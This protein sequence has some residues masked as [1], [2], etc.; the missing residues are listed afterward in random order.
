[1]AFPT[2]EDL[3]DYTRNERPTADDALYQ[4]AIDAAIQTLCDECQREFVVAGSAAARTFVPDLQSDY[5]YIGDCTSVTSVVENSI[6]LTVGTDY[7]LEP[8]TRTTVAGLAIPYNGLRRLDGNWYTHGPR[9]T[10]VVTATWGFA[11]LP[12]RIVEACKV[13]AKDVVANRDVQLGLVAVTEQAGVSARTNPLVRE[14]IES[15]AGRRSWGIG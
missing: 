1:M 13:L 8:V 11:A 7:Q 3:K 15:Y 4:E 2:V 14:T 6:T 5:L 12:A 9:G 10:V